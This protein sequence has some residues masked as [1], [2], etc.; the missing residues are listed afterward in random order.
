[1]KRVILFGI[2]AL[3]FVGCTKDKF[4]TEPQVEI[5]S[6]APDEVFNDGY[7][8]LRALIRDKEG[9]LQDTITTVWKRYNIGD[10]NPI[11]SD[12]V[13]YS[14]ASFGFPTSSEIDFQMNFSYAEDRPG[15]IFINLE[16]ADREFAIGLIVKDKAGHLSEFRESDKIVLKKL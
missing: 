10:P 6:L 2:V 15:Y 13:R 12:T 8:S 11:S 16:N 1:M 4:K 9:D 14:L 5:K 7:F 3:V